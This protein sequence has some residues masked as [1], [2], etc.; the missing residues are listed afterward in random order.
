M[1]ELLASKVLDEVRLTCKAP[2]SPFARAQR[3]QGVGRWLAPS[4]QFQGR[5]PVSS[6]QTTVETAQ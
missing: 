1:E 4:N 3:T 6:A 5:N 2:P